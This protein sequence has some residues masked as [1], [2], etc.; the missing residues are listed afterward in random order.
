L[1][2]AKTLGDPL[3][4][5]P[6]FAPR[7]ALSASLAASVALATA[8][9]QPP[10]PEPTPAARPTAIIER[11][12]PVRTIDPN[13]ELATFPSEWSMARASAPSFA[14]S[15]MIATNSAPGTKAGLEILRRG[16]NAVDAAVAVGFAMAVSYP[17]AGNLGGG[18]FLVVRMADGRTAALDFRERAPARATHDMYLDSTGGVS[19]D[20]RIGHRASGVPGS[21]AGLLS[22]LEKYGTMSRRDVLA[23]AIR[24][25]RD[26]VEVD[27]SLH[28]SLERARAKI[29]RFGGGGV[30]Y[31][32]GAVPAIGAKL[33]QPDLVRTLEAIAERGANGFYRGPVADSI[34]AEMRRGGGLITNQDLTSYR[35]AWRQPIVGTY[36]GH[37]L[38]TMPPSSSG[39]VTVLE[40]LN[41]L[42]S[43]PESAPFGSTTQLHR[44]VNAFQRAYLDRNENLGDPDFVRMPIGRLTDKAYASRMRASMSDTRATPTAA[45][46][47]KPGPAEGTN[48]TNISVADAMGNLAAMTTTLNEL[49]G[50]GVWVS[51]AG[52]F[53]NDE[54]DD[55]S[56]KPGS[57][58]MF[59]L[60]QGEANAIAPG[61]RML[62]A[63][64]PTIVV[65]PSGQPLM[66]VGGRG[67]SRIISAVVQAI[68][69]VID[70][71]M[72]LG[73]A[74]GAPRMHYQSLPDTVDFEAGGLTTAVVD[75]LR[76]MG[77]A[78]QPGGTGNLTAI[79]RVP[80]GWQG[81]Y[82]P[83]KHGLASG[84]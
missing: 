24:L 43:Y 62:S 8:C 46:R 59:G 53:M 68:V 47:A 75:S 9:R 70:H 32:G 58:N 27:T 52:F 5:V 25:A 74:I 60:V 6:R 65:D 7:S 81:A 31:P 21:V 1:R 63:M 12:E 13:S 20:S 80:G 44:L 19:M 34:V 49:Y 4:P 83:R 29:T 56:A 79:L 54:M 33:V 57:P 48:T 42:E 14:P 16:G 18:G 67:G 45:L 26:G 77:H 61:K 41:I 55:F 51:G 30:F 39:G 10:P 66:I 84:Y 73:E 76:A 72:A 69:N 50:S 22:A 82:D 40:S 35:A 17:E 15:A 38:V 11:R 37:T 71:H 3:V 2:G 23:P 28:N 36:R 64:A 78:L